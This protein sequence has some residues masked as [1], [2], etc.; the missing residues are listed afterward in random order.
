MF[1][2]LSFLTAAKM[3]P[4]LFMEIN[5]SAQIDFWV[6]LRRFVKQAERPR[7]IFADVEVP[8]R[9]EAL[10]F[11]GLT[12]LI[13]LALLVI[14]FVRIVVLRVGFDLLAFMGLFDIVCTTILIIVFLLTIVQMASFFSDCSSADSR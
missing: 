12:L 3:D 7:Y 13:D 11:T 5:S 10:F 6:T 1:S 14:I 2:K 4:K 9:K 8:T